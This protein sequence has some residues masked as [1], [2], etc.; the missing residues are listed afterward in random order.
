[1]NKFEFIDGIISSFDLP[2]YCGMP[3]LNRIPQ[4]FIIYDYYDM[5]M[6]A[7]DNTLLATKVNLTIHIV[8]DRFDGGLVNRVKN[9]LMKK[10]FEYLGDGPGSLDDDLFR[11]KKI[12]I[13]EFQIDMEEN[14]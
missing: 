2:F 13:L 9:G 11:G 6:H 8:A 7:A 1:M 3:E 12:R 4:T 10:G 5:P 14:L